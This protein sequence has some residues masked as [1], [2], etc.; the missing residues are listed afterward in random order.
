MQRLAEV[1][2]RDLSVGRLYEG[3]TDALA[4]LA[5]A[6]RAPHPGS[7]YGV[8]AARSPGEPTT[9]TPTSTGWSLSGPKEFCSGVG[10][11]ERALVTAEAPDGYRLLEVDLT[12]VGITAVDGSWPAVGM[13]GSASLTVVFDSA[14]VGEDATVGGPGFYTGRPGFWFG[15][16]GVAACW[17][18]GARSLV[19]RLLDGL[20]ATPSDHKLIEVGRAVAQVGAMRDALETAAGD[21]DAD[22]HDASGRARY[23]TLEVRETVHRACTHVLAQVAEAGGA[24]PL[25]HDGA[26]ARRAADLYVYLSQHH[27]AADA[28]QLGRLALEEGARWR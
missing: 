2:A 19:D 11:L 12:G 15:G 8:W 21:I 3:H 4:I 10:I 28:A 27:G 23:R 6:G 1:S 24:R 18:G 22:P 17:Y 5:E 9:A 26:Q 7:V 14:P 20:P 13:Q 25:T 16:A